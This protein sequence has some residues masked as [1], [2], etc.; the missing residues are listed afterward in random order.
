[1]KKILMRV[2][3]LCIVA[4]M[5]FGVTAQADSFTHWETA[6]T[7]LTVQ[8]RDMYRPLMSFGGADLGLVNADGENIALTGITDIFCTPEGMTYLL[9]GDNEGDKE[10]RGGAKGRLYLLNPDYT[11]NREII[12][13]AQDGSYVSYEGALGVYVEGET[14]Y[15][16]D[17]ARD[18]ILIL[19][20]NDMVTGEITL[21]D[22]DVIPDNITFKPCEIVRDADDNL[23]VLSQTSY[24]GAIMFNTEMEF[25]GFYGAN[26]VE[27]TVLDVLG[28]LWEM[29]TT[30]DAKREQQQSKLPDMFVS[31]A[32]DSNG[33]IYTTTATNGKNTGQVRMLSPGG[34]N[35]L[36]SRDLYGEAGDSGGFNFYEEKVVQK[37]DGALQQKMSVIDIN[38]NGYMYVLD[39]GLGY[40]Y[41]YDSDCN[42]LS[43]FGGGFG[44]GNELG[45]FKVPNSMS[46]NG[47]HLL[48]GDSGTNRVTVYEM[49]EYGKLVQQAETLYLIGDYVD[50]K[51]LWEEVLAMDSNSRL[52]YRGLGKAYYALGDYE[53]AMKYAEAAYDYVTYDQAYRQVRNARISKNFVVIFIAVVVLVALLVAFLIIIKKRERSM[54]NNIK[55]R[56]LMN[57]MVH[58]FQTFNDIKYK[59]YGSLPI[60]VVLIALFAFTSTVRITSSSFLFRTVDVYNYNSL[61]TLATTAGLVILFIVTNWLACTLM[62]GKGTMTEI[63]IAT[64]YS[65]LPMIIYNVAYT[66]L[67][68]VLSYEDAALLGALSTVMI[69]FTALLLI[70]SIMTVHEYSFGKLIW[71][72]IVTAF[73]MILLVF[74]IF[75][76]VILFQ[77]LFDF[78]NTLYTEVAYR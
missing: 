16:C 5:L 69:I 18:R 3:T 54:F 59:G 49:T 47:D 43:A 48:V 56:T 27:Y 26:T 51:T 14:V 32:V 61:F 71:S 78:V 19:D 31:M 25:T 39:S 60:A 50:S 66:I 45:K 28:N 13:T 36:K 53:E 10:I 6:G 2:V 17:T 35:I 24:Y 20:A 74:V 46:L 75:M 77:Q 1:M 62:E 55:L 44:E 38:D 34:T 21:P 68:Y 4:V 42:L 7:Q 57:V 30:T 40:I 41:I 8:T 33:Y 63:T 15:L 64:S 65:V 76:M 23:Y 72:T 58:P 12:V 37:A 73:F 67:S 29:L 9:C 22:S 70:V 52:A 11:L